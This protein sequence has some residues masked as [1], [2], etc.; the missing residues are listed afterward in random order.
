MLC[1]AL[2]VALSALIF[3]IA[4]CLLLRATYSTQHSA[5]LVLL[6]T[7]E[8]AKETLIPTA[9][10]ASGLE[11]LEIQIH[12]HRHNSVGFSARMS[13]H[14]NLMTAPMG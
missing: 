6:K 7:L 14:I 9:A 2:I 5:M 4:C 3:H 13:A 12:C 1:M 8:R 11:A 10:L